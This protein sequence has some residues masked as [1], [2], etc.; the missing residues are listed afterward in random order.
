MP[1]G[2]RYLRRCV[3]R[4]SDTNRTGGSEALDV[5]TGACLIVLSDT[6]SVDVN[7]VQLN[8]RP[9]FYI[10]R[11]VSPATIERLFVAQLAPVGSETLR[12]APERSAMR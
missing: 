6:A 9:Q 11:F 10:S 7:S 8:G 1:A 4:L 5:T 3:Y 12:D 2:C